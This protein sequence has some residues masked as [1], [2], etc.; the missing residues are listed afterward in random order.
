MEADSLKPLRRSD[1]T[2]NERRQQLPWPKDRNFRILSIDG[3]GIRGIL[4][5]AILAEFERQ[6]LGGN[7]AGDYFDLIAGT[8]TG[9]IIAL[10]LSIGVPATK[11]LDLY[12][13]HGAEIFPA[14][15]PPFKSIKQF[16]AKV[17]SL[18]YYQYSREPLERELRQIFGTLKFGDTQRR[19]CI[20][21]FDGFTEVNV[22]KTPHHPD[23][24]LDWREEM[25]TVALATSAA[26]TYFSVYKDGQRRFADGGVW[27]NNPVMV[28]LVDALTCNMIERDQIDIL[29]IGCGDTE[30]LMSDSQIGR[31]GLWHWR[32]I[33]SSAM[34]LT[35]QNALGQAGLLIGRD[36]LIR[37]NAPPLPGGAIGLDDVVRAKSEL[38]GIAKC[39]AKQHAPLIEAR[40][41]ANKAEPYESYHGENT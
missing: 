24:K 29:S 3:G 36:R 32:E 15:A 21:S 9:G 17:R 14:A 18:D 11:I 25:V 28:A 26:P 6:Y 38:P 37:L 40:F 20:P 30:I 16:W 10:G 7:S 12:V 31:G 13:E 23:F 4:P 34:H 5:A 39:L 1:G 27:A 8:S 19:L 35:S 22:F 2:L 33:V 41:F